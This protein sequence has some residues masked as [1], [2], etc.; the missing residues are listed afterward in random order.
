M[1]LSR[2]PSFGLVLLSEEYDRAKR[3]VLLRLLVI[4]AIISISSGLA[5]YALAGKTLEPLEKSIAEQKRFISDAAH[6]LRTPLTTLR[7]EI[8]VELRNKRLNLTGAK[9][10][11][12]SNL[13]EVSKMQSLAN[14]LLLLNRYESGDLKLE[15]SKIDLSDIAFEIIKK[16]EPIAKSKRI[17]I[18]QKLNVAKINGNRTSIEELISILMDNAIK[19]SKTGGKIEVVTLQKGKYASLKIKDSGIGIKASEIPFIFN[20]FYRADSS[21]CKEN[22]DGYGLGLSIAQSIANSHDANIEVESALGRGSVFQVSFH[23]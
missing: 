23:S 4:D 14:Y 21:R 3:Q 12:N 20:R 10:L 6:E 17:T 16:Y 15:L 7:T 5:A 13:E 19:Y 8:E 22:I 18:D 1:P 9:K 2:P 11:L